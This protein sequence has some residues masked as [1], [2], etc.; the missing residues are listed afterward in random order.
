MEPEQLKKRAE[1]IAANK[2]RLE[3][4]N[5]LDTKLF[6]WGVNSEKHPT[7][8]LGVFPT[9]IVYLVVVPLLGL[10]YGLS[11]TLL[12]PVMILGAALIA[13]VFHKNRK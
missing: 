3:K 12:G 2:A 9:I 8:A 10:I 6:A 5:S 11:F 7:H 1:A 4:A 13:V